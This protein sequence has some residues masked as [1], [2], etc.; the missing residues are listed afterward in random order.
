MLFRS[1]DS[2]TFERFDLSELLTDLFI[3]TSF[4]IDILLLNKFLCNFSLSNFP[5]RKF[6]KLL[7]KLLFIIYFF[8]ENGLHPVTLCK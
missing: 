6:L 2:C 8:L 4:L 5:F 3:K 1:S 7:L